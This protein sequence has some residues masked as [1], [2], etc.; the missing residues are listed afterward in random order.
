MAPAELQLLQAAK[1]L[2]EHETLAALGLRDGS[3]LFL[4]RQP[5]PR[6]DPRLAGACVR[7]NGLSA[8]SIDPEGDQLKGVVLC[9]RPLQRLA[10]GVR[11]FEVQIDK[12]RTGHQDG[13]A[14]GV[15]SM[16]PKSADEIPVMSCDLPASWSYGYDG[17]ASVDGCPDMLPISWNPK[18]LRAGE[19]VGL[20][21]A[22]NG[23][24]ELFLNRSSVAKL[25]GS[26]PP[27][28]NLTAFVDIIGNTLAVSMLPESNPPLPGW[29]A[30]RPSHRRG[31]DPDCVLT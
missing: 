19:K 26:A 17:S 29:M 20:L 31:A 9:D 15:T 14:I 4:L 21:I 22:A 5:M 13:L 6:F 28:D 23:E 27:E 8:E 16:P 18:H 12:V 10:G 3:S 30:Q 1:P 24:L 25:P 11:Y 2:P 7:V